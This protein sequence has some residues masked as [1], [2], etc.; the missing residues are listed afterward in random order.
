MTA[1]LVD[2]KSMHEKKLSAR[3]AASQKLLDSV[4]GEAEELLRDIA[5]VLHLTQKVRGEIVQEQ[6]KEQ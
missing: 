1:T 5:Y 2:S 4:R 3:N 6:S